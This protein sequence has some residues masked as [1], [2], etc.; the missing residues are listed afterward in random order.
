MRA[1][2]NKANRDYYEKDAPAITDGEY[3][4]KMRRLQQLEA[5]FPALQSA[6]SPANRVGG[7]AT[8]GFLP[9]VH[10]SR[11]FSLANALSEDEALQFFARV[12]DVGPFACELKLDG[13]AINLVY[14]NG[15]LQTAATRGDGE[16]GEGITAN[17]KAAGGV[18]AFLEGAPPLLE[19]R[20]EVVMPFAD[21]ARLNERQR[22][23]G[24]KIF[25]NPRN[26]A[27]GSLRQ[28]NAQVAGERRLFFYPHGV[29]VGGISLAASHWRAMEWLA[30]R[31]F[32]L[33]APRARARDTKSVLAYYRRVEQQRADIPFSIDGVVYKVDDFAK[34]RALGHV[35]RAPR[36]AVAHKFSAQEATT[37]ICAI[38][39][40]VGR[41]GLLTPVARLAPVSVGGV[42]VANA[43]LHNPAFVSE[44]D[45]RVGDT[46]DV[47]RAGDVIP[48]IARVHAKSRPPAARPWRA[49]VRCPSCRGVVINDGRFCRCPYPRCRQRRLA[50][51]AHFVS[52]QALDID[53]VGDVLLEKLFA[54]RLLATPA[55]LFRLRREDLLPLQF[56]ADV[57]A[58][59]ILAAINKAK[60]TTLPRLLFALGIP[61]VGE[62]AA[63]TLADFFGSVAAAQK[64]PPAVYALVP[65]I[66]E[67]TAAAL[68]NYFADNA[69]AQFLADLLDSSRPGW[70]GARVVTPPL[71]AARRRPLALF[72]AALPKFCSFDSAAPELQG[73]GKVG[74]KNLL[75]VC[76]NLPALE[77]ACDDVA[78]ARQTPAAAALL[79]AAGEK[80]PTRLAA[81]FAAPFYI[82][83]RRFLRDELL[84]EWTQE[85][86]GEGK[87]LAGKVF[88]LTGNLPN[89]S[90]KAATEKIVAAGG[91][92]AGSVSGNTA[93]VVA[94]EKPGSKLREAQKRNI[95]VIDE[96]Q[97]LALC[98]K[99]AGEGGGK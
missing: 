44:L 92:V 58:D 90:R 95:A 50:Q 38:D 35:T 25:A 69:N 72:L 49:P 97:L 8:R 82:A 41:T 67:E 19:V 47:L 68:Q 75:S 16:T 64:A 73:L 55:D 15:K 86:E 43:T 83:L 23:A 71:A 89:L 34:Q 20:G 99:G 27:A 78:R 57:S 39:M 22:Q 70:A 12:G 85:A 65:D 2:I 93:F 52:R 36:H 94:G 5:E 51:L 31:G 80:L 98:G 24:G 62:A 46:V 53:G 81:F 45:A 4:K 48:K 11:M 79:A 37:R 13:I 42:V 40:Q 29:G 61:G 28:L 33:A 63:A 17:V 59:N 30:A 91:A 3:D 1:V 60:Q 76:Q 6:D 56:V 87:P 66:G 14:A 10:P 88:V 7:R 21:F 9:F 26:A 96:G 84:L 54:A 74:I 77:S 18:P 32:L